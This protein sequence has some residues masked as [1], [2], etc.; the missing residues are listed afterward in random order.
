MPL[1]K[2]SSKK[3]VGANIAE[4]KNS[5]Y[6][7]AQAVAIAMNKA[8]KSKPEKRSRPSRAD[9]PGPRAFKGGEAGVQGETQQPTDVVGTTGPSPWVRSTAE[10]LLRKDDEDEE[11]FQKLVRKRRKMGVSG[12]PD[13]LDR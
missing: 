11:G 6:N 2:G 7:E 10:P 4:L 13:Y 1:F 5:G 9:G 3:I 8:G 12:S